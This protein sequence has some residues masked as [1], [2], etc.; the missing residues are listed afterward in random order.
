MNSTL[1]GLRARGKAARLRPLILTLIAVITMSVL[2]FAQ[3]DKATMEE[4]AAKNLQWRAIGPAN[5]GGRIDD[6]AV[7]ENNPSIIYAGAA[8]GGVWKTTNNGTTWDPVFD[9]QSSTSIGDICLAPADP[10][11]VWVGTGEP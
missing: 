10:N 1:L 8:T 2:A 11:I 3:E 5:M 4:M 7:V 6:F 9:D